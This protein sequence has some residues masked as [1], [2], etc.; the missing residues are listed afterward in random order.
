MPFMIA[1]PSCT[2]RLK[3]EDQSLGRVVRCPRC[4]Q[5]VQVAAP[6]GPPHATPRPPV[7]VT[8]APPPTRDDRKTP[9]GLKPLDEVLPPRKTRLP[10]PPDDD[11]ED[12]DEEERPHGRKRRRRRRDPSRF[13]GLVP[14][15]K[16]TAGLGLLFGG[17]LVFIG[18]QDYR[19]AR[20]GSA[21]PQTISGAKLTA[22]GPGDNIHV[23][24]RDFTFGE[25]YITLSRGKG[26]EARWH[27][28]IIPIHPCGSKEVKV[29]VL[30]Y[31][32]ESAADVDKYCQRQELTGVI[33]NEME[34]LS[35]QE[36][37]ELAK[38]Y[39]GVDFSRVW[40]LHP[41][42]YFPAERVK[43]LLGIGIPLLLVG[44]GSGL[45]LLIFREYW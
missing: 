30:I 27:R 40:V 20:L 22:D 38:D 26:K 6:P 9:F 39:P 10:P 15:Y 34:T 18:W 3:V 32:V 28:A 7:P 29:V 16:W 35:G 17:L 41:D 42:R 19:L 44:L 31:S 11:D 43:L 33:I 1:C 12:E 24:V 8:P 36:Q 2:T 25:K 37:A 45:L 4:G 5:P 13:A 23:R 21:E 14:L